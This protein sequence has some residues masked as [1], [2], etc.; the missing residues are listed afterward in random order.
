MPFI[1]YNQISTAIIEH[2]V[3]I[4]L[5]SGTKLAVHVVMGIFTELIFAE[6]IKRYFSKNNWRIIF[7]LCLTVRFSICVKKGLNNTGCKQHVHFI[8]IIILDF[9]YK[10]VKS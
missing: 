2:L 1:F 8:L 4:I 7:C 6:L 5:L 3:F 9:I 10:Q